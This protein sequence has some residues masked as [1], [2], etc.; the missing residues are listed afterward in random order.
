V[1]YLDISYHASY[2][3]I[4]NFEDEAKILRSFCKDKENK[5]VFLELF[6]EEDVA[7]F[8]N[9]N[10][11][12]IKIMDNTVVFKEQLNKIS[13]LHSPS[14]TLDIRNTLKVFPWDFSAVVLKKNQP[15]RLEYHLRGYETDDGFGIRIKEFK[16]CTFINEILPLLQKTQ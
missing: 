2:I 10:N 8:I 1:F 7:A 4:E 16:N 12:R 15:I 3:Y 13:I 6:S 14:T 11:H 9:V 5:L